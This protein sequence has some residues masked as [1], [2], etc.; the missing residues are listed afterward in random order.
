MIPATKTKIIKCF[1]YSVL[2]CVYKCILYILNYCGNLMIIFI[3][4]YKCVIQKYFLG[5]K[6][7]NCSIIIIAWEFSL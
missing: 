6:D 7:L 1:S 2:F 4:Q 3:I 5:Y